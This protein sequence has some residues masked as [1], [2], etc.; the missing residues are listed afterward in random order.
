MSRSTFFGRL[1][2]DERGSL[3]IVLMVV[4]T[5]SVLIG[6]LLD[7]VVVATKGSRR[8]GDAANALQ[9]ADAGVNDATQSITN[10][11]TTSFTRT[12]TIGDGSYTYT[13]TRD[14]NVKSIW[15]IDSI[16]TDGTGVK[17][18]IQADAS[19]ISEF[20]S[21]LYVNNLL[22]NVA[23]STLDSYTSGLNNTTGCTRH[24]VISVADGNNMSFTG[25]GGGNANC[26]GRIPITTWTNS[27]DGC[28]VYG[29]TN[30][31]STGAARCPS[32]PYTYRSDE[33]FPLIKVYAPTSGVTYPSSNAPGSSF[34]CNAASGSNSLKAGAI[35][36][37]TTFTL[38]D[39]C[40]IDPS[41]LP[42][43]SPVTIYAKNLVIGK[44]NG[45]GSSH[46]V[47]NAP[48]TST[49]PVSTSGWTYTDVGNNPSHYYCSGWPEKVQIFIPS[50]IG[51][52][53][54]T[55]GNNT[56]FWGLVNAP[57]ATMSINDPQ[58]EMWGAM[59]LGSL[60]ASSQ[61]SWHYDDALAQVTVGGYQVSNWRE[62]AVS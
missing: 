32:P 23:G 46:A 52:T 12:G 33:A 50:G 49:C 30:L 17:R 59:V 1:R 53:I 43:T 10:I 34:T 26:T 60:S 4:I 55:Y 6:A 42:S 58:F 19:G 27:M 15:H 38:H 29:G 35:Y 11:A 57:D 51:G 14:P 36:Y 41:T 40:R 7:E 39:G 47:I 54:N 21:P 20:T 25:S 44:S 28:V 37:Y 45:S 18:R 48:S 9:L 56:K 3:I 5:S 31:P 2:D 62:V 13:A 61:F 24:G 22:T 16:G 8:A